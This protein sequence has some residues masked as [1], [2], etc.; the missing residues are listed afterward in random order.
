MDHTLLDVSPFHRKNFLMV[1]NKIFGITELQKVVT[2]GVPMF[3]VMRR[4]CC[5]SRGE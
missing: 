2:S 3:E 5:S 4:F 1:L